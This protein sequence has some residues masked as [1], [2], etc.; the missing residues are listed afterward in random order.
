MKASIGIEASVI[1][2]VEIPLQYIQ[3]RKT[4]N[5]DK[6][7]KTLDYEHNHESLNA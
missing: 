4:A 2:N 7:K 5:S 3:Y 6:K 1:I